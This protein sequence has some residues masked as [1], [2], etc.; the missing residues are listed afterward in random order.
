M[1]RRIAVGRLDLI[2]QVNSL[3]VQEEDL[4]MQKQFQHQVIRIH[5]LMSRQIIMKKFAFDDFVAAMAHKD[6]LND[7]AEGTA[8][9]YIVKTVQVKV[10]K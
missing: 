9:T 4:E 8:L 1:I 7:K 3:I 10:K 5:P 2:H 6:E